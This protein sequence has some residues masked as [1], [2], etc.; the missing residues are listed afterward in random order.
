[1][2]EIIVEFVPDYTKLKTGIQELAD[3]GAIKQEL[4]QA[5]SQAIKPVD[6]LTRKV[7]TGSKAIG[8]DLDGMRQKLKALSKDM[9]EGF[10]EGIADAL[11][12]AGVTMEEFLD[13]LNKTTGAQKS[14]KQQLKET[15]EQLAQL[16]LEGKEN[17]DQYKQL[18]A[19][20]GELSDTLADVAAETRRVGS[21]TRK[22]DTAIEIVQGLGAAYQIAQAGAALL[23]TEND[24]LQRGLLRLQAIMAITNGI[25]QIQNLLQ[26][27]SNAIKLV[28]VLQT[29]AEVAAIRLQ[30]AA[31]SRNIVVSTLATGAMKALNLVMKAN[32]ALL[33]VSAFAAL[34]GAL[35]LFSGKSRKA[36]SDAALLTLELERQNTI[37]NDNLA[38]IDQRTKI[39]IA[40]ARAAGKSEGE[41]TNITI[42]GLVQQKIAAQQSLREREA[43]AQ[44]FFKN[45]KI[46]AGEQVKDY[47]SA[48]NAI[49][50]INKVLAADLPDKL[51][52]RLEGVKTIFESL[53]Q[54][55]K[56]VADI[57]DNISLAA[58][59][60]V[61]DSA[62]RQRQ[63]QK[64]AA[65]K[66]KQDA[67]KNAAQAREIELQRLND[68]KS[69]IEKQLLEEQEG[70]KQFLK[71]QVDLAA[72]EKNIGIFGAKSLAE[73][74]LL[75][76]QFLK[77][78]D[79]MTTEYYVNDEKKA[80]E[81]QISILNAQLSNINI[82]AQEREQLTVQLLNRQ[83]ALELAEVVNNKEKEKEINAK[84]D[85]EIADALLAI[86]QQS[87]DE[88]IQLLQ[89]S[90]AARLRGLRRIASDERQAI[91][92]RINALQGIATSELEVL[93]AR[94]E[95]LDNFHALGLISEQQYQLGLAEINDGILQV[96]ENLEQAKT[97]IVVK[98]AE[99]R[100][101]KNTEVLNQFLEDASAVGNVLG[102]IFQTIADRETADLQGRREQL[103]ELLDAGTISEKEFKER[104]KRI[105]AEEKQARRRAAARE[106]EMQLFQAFITGA[107]AVVEA[108]PD[109][110]RIGFTIALVAAQIAAIASR[111]L[112]RFGK[113]TKHA[114]KGPAEVGETGAE[115]IANPST[116]EYYLASHPQV[117]WLKGGERIY[118]P[119][120]TETIMAS[121]TPL[122]DAG[123]TSGYSGGASAMGI[124]EDKL[125]RKIGE[126]IA[127]HPK[128]VINL[129]E[130]G[131]TQHI[132]QQNSIM[133]YRNK[134]YTYNA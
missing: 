36:A 133:T 134:R 116:G 131:F 2:A 42:S 65:D 87:L 90:D 31:Q 115:I 8:K 122:A 58:V 6:D 34:A 62:E 75:I 127:R 46:L 89:L 15:K 64:E 96:Y 59:D 70:T 3:S 73:K 76:A 100:K 86:K 113:G 102:Q 72:A 106:K 130:D 83:R 63:A 28:T 24:Q 27:E 12:E 22:I 37:L 7:N 4:A 47:A 20:A 40:R 121:A 118:N 23:G 94:K 68:V 52:T 11:K 18:I 39:A 49:F 97:D 26:K 77:K 88:E 125:A 114:P 117:I 41:L 61:A 110:F 38:G 5:F 29:K 19:T 25:Q 10:K 50:E 1:M 84:Y 17:T 74:E 44:T 98:G 109:P 81:A 13:Q 56:Q 33:L 69:R 108:A 45:Q 82:S 91:D 99:D 132:I 104:S 9:N 32:P 51:K 93:N 60:A 85:K 120:E 67:E 119:K 57:Q 53:A 16:K 80:I 126:E 14:L 103:Q 79:D 35:T 48:T 95:G 66:A 92:D 105:E 128:S 54:S 21:D 43:A 78:V 71:L 101:Q 129:D 107:R 112:P 124:N 123:L 30:T 55:Y 111:P